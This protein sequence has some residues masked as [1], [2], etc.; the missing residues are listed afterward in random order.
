MG[1]LDKRIDS[2]EQRLGGREPVR[3]NVVQE[4][5]KGREDEKEFLYTVTV[6]PSEGNPLEEAPEQGE[7]WGA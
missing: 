3:I 6:Y 4:G 1:S 7:S 2:L 5:P